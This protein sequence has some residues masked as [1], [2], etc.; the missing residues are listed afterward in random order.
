M[1]D[2]SFREILFGLSNQ[3]QIRKF[4]KIHR[5][6]LVQVSPKTIIFVLQG[7]QPKPQGL[8]VVT[9]RGTRF[10]FKLTNFCNVH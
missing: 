9:P 1:N 5:V 4:P 7:D 6:R 2:I 8:P 3:R 10:G